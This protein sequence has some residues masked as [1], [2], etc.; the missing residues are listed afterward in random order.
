M[1]LLNGILQ[2]LKCVLQTVGT[3]NA[4]I[5]KK[6]HDKLESLKDYSIRIIGMLENRGRE[7]NLKEDFPSERCPEPVL[8]E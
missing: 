4:F 8:G 7:A 3:I 2:N 5:A 1:E 6:W